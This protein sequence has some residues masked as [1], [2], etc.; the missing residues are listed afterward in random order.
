MKKEQK[1]DEKQQEEKAERR[2]NPTSPPELEEDITAMNEEQMYNLLVSLVDT[3]YW[4]AIKKFFDER[5][6]KAGQ[7]LFSLDPF[8]NPSDMSKIQ[9]LRM[10][11]YSL[12]NEIL[13]EIERR[14][15]EERKEAGEK[16]EE[17]N[18]DP[19]YNKF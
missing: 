14:K 5:G 16:T 1:K 9:G 13:K 12:E 18:F 11:Y 2:Y 4:K 7:S 3:E 19:G 17:D 15:E 6:R 10:G 8:K